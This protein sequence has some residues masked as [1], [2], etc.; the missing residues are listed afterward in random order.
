MFTASVEIE[1]RAER[2][3]RSPTRLARSLASVS[4]EARAS[5]RDNI[6]QWISEVKPTC[7]GETVFRLGSTFLANPGD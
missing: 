2:Y 1:S 7:L 4:E 5:I 3:P 6:L